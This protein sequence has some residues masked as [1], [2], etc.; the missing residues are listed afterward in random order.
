MACEVITD[1][2]RDV[3]PVVVMYFRFQVG[4]FLAACP[5]EIESPLFV[6]AKSNAVGQD[7]SSEGGAHGRMAF[8]NLV[9]I[10]LPTSNRDSKG[11]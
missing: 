4:N 2:T 8:K 5:Q 7:I 6:V 10:D 3:C 1:L 11:F 9:K